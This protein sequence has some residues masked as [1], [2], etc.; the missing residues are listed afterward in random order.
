MV[1]FGSFAPFV[2]LFSCSI[3]FDTFFLFSSF[4]AAVK[5]KQSFFLWTRFFVNHILWICMDHSRNEIWM[6]VIKRYFAFR[7]TFDGIHSFFQFSFAR[8]PFFPLYSLM[9]GEKNRKSYAT[10]YH[11]SLQSPNIY[12]KIENRLI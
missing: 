7:L 8:A 9:H 12:I 11:Y 6:N 1:G 4:W 3:N 10:K 5:R 2:P